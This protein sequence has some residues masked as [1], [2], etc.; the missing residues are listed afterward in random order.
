M[1]KADIKFTADG[2]QRLIYP[3]GDE[4]QRRG[5]FGWAGRRTA[6][7]Y[8]KLCL[9]SRFCGRCPLTG[10]RLEKEFQNM[11]ALRDYE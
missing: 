5:F 3:K 7:R 6:L 8:G 10:L 9:N 2:E 4:A 1:Y 11:C